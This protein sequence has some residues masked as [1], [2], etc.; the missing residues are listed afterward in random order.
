M[1]RTPSVPLLLT[2]A[3]RVSAPFVTVADAEDR[4]RLTLDSIARWV[5]VSPAVPIVVCDGSGYDFTADCTLRFPGVAIECLAFQNDEKQVARFGKGYGEGQIINHALAHSRLLAQSP[6]F[7]KCTA[8]LWVENFG[9]VM[10]VARGPFQAELSLRPGPSRFSYK[11]NLIDTRFFVADKSFFQQFLAEAYREVRDFDNYSYEHAV[12]D[13][14]SISL[15]RTQQ[16]LFHVP[17]HY[18][19]ISGTTGEEYRLHTEP[20]VLLWQRRKLIARMH[21]DDLAQRIVNCL[22]GLRR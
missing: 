21:V 4:R 8:K 11:V 6:R 9:D 19:G 15:L 12:R 5:S 13:A 3:V 1:K 18:R 22:E 2:S 7:A 16:I 10:A 20:K 14:V 17:V